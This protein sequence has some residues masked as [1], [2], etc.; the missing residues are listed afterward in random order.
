MIQTILKKKEIFIK[1]DLIEHTGEFLFNLEYYRLVEK[2]DKVKSEEYWEAIMKLVN[3]IDKVGEQRN[4][5]P[6]EEIDE[7]IRRKTLTY[8]T[9]NNKKP[10]DIFEYEVKST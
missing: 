2:T 6:N 5:Q 7:S 9:K 10:E 8:L 1:N 3:T 4:I